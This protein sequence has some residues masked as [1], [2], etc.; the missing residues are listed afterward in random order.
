MSLHRNYG[1][2]LSKETIS[3]SLKLLKD[4]GLIELKATYKNDGTRSLNEYKI[5]EPKVFIESFVF[6]KSNSTVKEEKV[7][8]EDSI[9]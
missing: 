6:N 4:N 7:E 5:L 9:W 2:K 8:L 3:K 1:T